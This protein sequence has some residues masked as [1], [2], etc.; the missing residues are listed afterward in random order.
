MEIIIASYSFRCEAT[1]KKHTEPCKDNDFCKIKL[2]EDGE[3]I[4]EHNFGSKSLR[5]NYAIY[6]DLE[7][8]LVKYDTCLNNPKDSYAVNNTQ[9]IPSGYSMLIHD[10]SSNSSK[11]LYYRDN[12]CIQD[13]CKKLRK[14][15]EKLFDTEKNPMKPLTQEQKGSYDNAKR[16]HICKS[17]F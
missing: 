16:C 9:H 15:G 10:N 1:L 12:D 11:V 17:S 8:L 7:C 13:L 4:K 3:N 5:M 14:I 6:V 2:L